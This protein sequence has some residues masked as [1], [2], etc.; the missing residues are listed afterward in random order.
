MV[1]KKEA[2]SS[3]EILT[4]H[5]SQHGKVVVMHFTR[6]ALPEGLEQAQNFARLNGNRD[7]VAAVNNYNN[8]F[9]DMDVFV[10]DSLERSWGFHFRHV[11]EPLTAFLS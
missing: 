6:L 7:A 9:A 3:L 2:N 11:G 4:S 5:I 1:I 10:F 8:A